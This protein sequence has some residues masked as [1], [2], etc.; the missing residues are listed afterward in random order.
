M[1]RVGLFA[2]FSKHY[3]LAQ[4]TQMVKT[5]CIVNSTQET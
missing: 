5:A 4:E 3:Q 2:I 1:T